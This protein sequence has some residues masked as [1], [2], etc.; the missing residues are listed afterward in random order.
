[1]YK[2][3]LVDDERVILEGIS[4]II[5]WEEMNASVV[6]MMQNGLDAYE[7]MKIEKPDIVI[8]DIKMPRMTGIE[9]V[10]QAAKAQLHAQFILLSGYG[11]FEYAQRA[12]KYGVMHYHLKP[13]NEQQM[14]TSLQAIMETMKVE[15]SKG[16]VQIGNK[17]DAASK[18]I[19][20]IHDQL[21][22]P[23]L[24][25]K[26]AAQEVLFLNPDYAGK[27]FKQK[28]G[29]KF[30]QYVAKQR[31]ELA[32]RKIQ[33]GSDAS[34]YDMAEELGFG[35]NPKYFSLVFKKYAGCTPSEYKK[36]AMKQR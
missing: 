3:V 5:K 1:M 7:L 21:A 2:V 13:C 11:E 30:S 9:L 10:E 15:P 23:S 27:L 31:I 26:W 16:G 12:M 4:S 25:L 18:M 17:E 33:G 35:H 24:S 6:G 34:L 32:M 22:N 29:E 36:K 14:K 8:S 28:T 20:L 19:H